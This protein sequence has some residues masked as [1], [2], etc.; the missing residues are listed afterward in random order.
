MTDTRQQDVA[1]RI[2]EC[3]G[4]PTNMRCRHAAEN[5]RLREALRVVAENEA[6]G[7]VAEH[8]HAALDASEEEE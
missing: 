6:L 7:V 2:R 1:L 3:C 4:Q 8:A 5:A